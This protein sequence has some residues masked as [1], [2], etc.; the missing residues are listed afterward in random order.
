MRSRLIQIARFA[1]APLLVFGIAASSASCGELGALG[2]IAQ[3][4]CPQIKPDVDAVRTSYSEVAQVNVKLRAFVQASKDLAAVADQAEA[5]AAEACTRMG[6]DLG[7]P[8]AQLA[9]KDGPGGRAEGPCNAV[10]GAIDAILRTGIQVRVQATP[11]QCEATGTAYAQCSGTCQVEVDPGQIV[12]QCEPAKLSGFC[13]G[14]CGG[15]CEGRCTGQCNGQ[16]SAVDAQ[17]R[18]AGQ[19]NGQCV[20]SCDATCHA[21]CQGT[22]QAPRCEASV[23]GPSADAQCDASCKAHAS[24]RARCTPAAVN[25]QTNASTEMAARLMR[26]L[27]TN[28][29][30]LLHA[31]IALGQRVLADA[32]ILARVGADLPNVIGQ[33]GA[34][35][36]ACVAAGANASARATA[37]LRVSVS[38]SA[39]VSGRVGAGG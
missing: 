17:G 8:P 25:V 3:A 19:C 35:A 33:A 7:I 21:Y 14:T 27:Q 39:S 38:V 10:A 12:A 16:C 31:Q 29:P 13:Q 2:D 20:G 26:T 6:N 1:L 5:E 11:P 30:L 23:R 37:S 18:C 24:F 4:A 36:V 22:W 28:L 9:P 32:D 34:N 15:R